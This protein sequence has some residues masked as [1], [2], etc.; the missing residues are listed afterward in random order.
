MPIMTILGDLG[1]CSDF[2]SDTEISDVGSRDAGFQKDLIHAIS[3]CVH[4]SGK[5]CGSVSFLGLGVL[6]TDSGRRQC[7]M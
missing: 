5:L 1:C 4:E 6:V 7:R 3:E 2:L